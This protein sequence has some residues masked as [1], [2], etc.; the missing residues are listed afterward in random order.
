M[1]TEMMSQNQGQ[2]NIKAKNGR[3]LRQLLQG[4]GVKLRS[5]VGFEYIIISAHIY[6][7][8]IFIEIRNVI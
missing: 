3:H 2:R 1:R 6:I 4:N 5:K 8:C 7:V